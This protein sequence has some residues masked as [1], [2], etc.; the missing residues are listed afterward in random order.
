[1]KQDFSNMIAAE[2][3]KALNSEE[4]Q[5]LF[6]SS[7]MLEKLAFK[8]VSEQDQVTDIEKELDASLTKT[9]AGKCKHCECAE[10]KKGDCKC[11]CHEDSS[12]KSSKASNPVLDAFNALLKIS[13]DLDTA[14]FDKLAA[15]SLLL[16]DKLVSEAKAKSSKKS[17]KKSD[18]KEDKKSKK[19]DM[20]ERMKKM[21]D[22]Q[23][24]KGKSKDKSKS[25]K[26]KVSKAQ[27]VPA[28]QHLEPMHA[29]KGNEESMIMSDP[30]AKGA[31]VDVELDTV[32]VHPANMVPVVTRVVQKLQ[33]ANKLPWN[34]KYRVVAA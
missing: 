27:A 14:G 10:S 5:K 11:D 29:P 19:M 30:A 34:R 23:K 13:D 12:S 2:M 3:D 7:S 32:K 22:M 4:N 31:Q 33:E 18:K 6:S 8:K 16:A 21:R 20:K 1:M 28:P 17:D 25:D 15:A 9:A 26:K 24:G